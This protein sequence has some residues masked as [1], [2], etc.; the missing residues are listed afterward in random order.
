M[1][2]PTS[3]GSPTICQ[4]A[5][6]GSMSLPNSHLLPME[7]PATARCAWL[8][9]CLPYTRISNSSDYVVF[10]FPHGHCL[11]MISSLTR[12][13]TIMISNMEL[14]AMVVQQEGY[15]IMTDTR[16][17]TTHTCADNTNTVSW[18]HCGSVSTN[19]ACAYLLCIQ[20]LH[21]HFHHYHP[22]HSYIP[23]PFYIMADISRM[24]HLTDYNCLLIAMLHIHNPHKV[25]CRMWHPPL[26]MLST[27]T[28]SLH[29]T[30]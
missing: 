22:T 20:V 17:C 11:L 13:G 6:L 24:Y 7:P 29:R 25:P 15:T 21:Q 10:Q 1:P 9:S 16:E 26:A 18:Q 3:L 28:S 27:V 12:S 19:S 4:L 8:A 5:P 2:L 14:L 30:R 23:W